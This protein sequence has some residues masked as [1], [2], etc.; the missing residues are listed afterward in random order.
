MSALDDHGEKLAAP[1][2]WCVANGPD[3][4]QAGSH[5][6]E[7]PW[8]K[9]GGQHERAEV[10]EVETVVADRGAIVDALEK[11]AKYG[12]VARYQKTG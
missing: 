1:C 3:Y 5:T 10:L 7:C 12:R 6:E 8:H 9:V 2:R 4:W 11:L